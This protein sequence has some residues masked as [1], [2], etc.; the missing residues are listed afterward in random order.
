VERLRELKDKEETKGHEILSKA[1]PA[2]SFILSISTQE[3][4]TL[5]ATIRLIN[6]KEVSG[7]ELVLG[8]EGSTEIVITKIFKELILPNYK[9]WKDVK[10]P[11]ANDLRTVF[12][13][14]E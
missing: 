6:E 14:Y 11:N 7:E 1:I 5:K 12:A 2:K 3:T 9:K 13:L 10:A 4:S 8:V